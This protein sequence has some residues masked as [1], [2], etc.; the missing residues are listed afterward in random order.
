MKKEIEIAV[1]YTKVVTEKR[2]I[3]LPEIDKYFIKD[4]KR[5]DS[6]IVLFAIILR[7]E[8]PGKYLL[9]KVS[10]NSQE[11]T[12]FHV[13]KDCKSEYWLKD[14]D[15]NLRREAL[16]IMQNN[17]EYEEITETDF[18]NKREWLLNLYKDNK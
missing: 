1:N 12:D 8:L 4:P 16:S 13:E 2:K 18:N 9:I 10:Y 6:G 17:W 3:E 7:Y 11:F 14:G 5:L 15:N